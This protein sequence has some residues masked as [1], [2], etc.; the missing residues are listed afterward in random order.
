MGLSKGR[1]GETG[2]RPTGGVQGHQKMLR[3]VHAL[4]RDLHVARSGGTR[5]AIARMELRL[6]ADARQTPPPG[7]PFRGRLKFTFP[8]WN[9]F[10]K[11][12]WPT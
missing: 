1:A 7:P 3:F 2:R 11:N 5:K 8:P 10:P 12:S 6:L 9:F 4:A